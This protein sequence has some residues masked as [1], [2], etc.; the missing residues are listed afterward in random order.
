[1]TVNTAPPRKPLEPLKINEESSQFI[2]VPRFWVD[3]L[4]KYAERIPASFWKFKLVLWRGITNGN[5]EYQTQL[6][7]SQFGLTKQQASKWKFAVQ[8]SGLYTVVTGKYIPKTSTNYQYRRDATVAEWVVFIKA[9]NEKIEL[10]TLERLDPTQGEAFGIELAILIDERRHQ[11]GLPR[12]NEKFIREC[13][14]DGRVVQDSGEYRAKDRRTNAKN[15]KIFSTTGK[16][17]RPG[18]E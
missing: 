13:L 6:A 7:L 9:L 12:V 16:D 8:V 18:D 4:F 1:M 15:R 3:E 14:R 10:D 17:V 5:R 11:A 2:R